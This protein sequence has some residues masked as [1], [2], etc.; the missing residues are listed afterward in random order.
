MGQTLEFGRVQ[1]DSASLAEVCR[2]YHIREL[3]L[4][5]SAARDE[6]RPDSDVDLM[7]EFE[8]GARVGM[9][10]F[11]SL[12]EELTGL[13]RRRVDLSRRSSQATDVLQ[14]CERI[15]KE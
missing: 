6:M 12:A 14:A 2:R 1:V 3:S 7:V 5:G 15:Q 11:E 4:F 10:N 9:I 13:A 8:P